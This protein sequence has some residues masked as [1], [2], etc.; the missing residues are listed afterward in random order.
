[1]MVGPG[2]PEPSPNSRSKAF[3]RPAGRLARWRVKEGWSVGAGAAVGVLEKTVGLLEK[4]EWNQ[5]RIEAQPV[6]SRS[7]QLSTLPVTYR[8]FSTNSS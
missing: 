3:H 7:P 2:V 8:C 5:G 4:A 6:R 1:M